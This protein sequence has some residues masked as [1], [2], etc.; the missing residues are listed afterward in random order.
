MSYPTRINDLYQIVL[1]E[2][3]Q[4]SLASIAL[5]AMMDVFWEMNEQLSNT[6][7][8]RVGDDAQ[9]AY[10]QR[11]GGYANAMRRLGDRPQNTQGLS[12]KLSVSAAASAT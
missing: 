2:T 12:P 9:G 5:D 10:A 3:V 11:S 4:N 6:V 7:R 8:E 1:S